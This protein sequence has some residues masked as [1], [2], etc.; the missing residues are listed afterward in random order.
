M[1]FYMVE[2]VGKEETA[3]ASVSPMDY[4]GY[5]TNSRLSL[6]YTT[7]HSI[8]FSMEVFSFAS[9]CSSFSAALFI[10]SCSDTDN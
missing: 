1:K 8:I 4:T 9:D 7:R 3:A 10:H 2:I 5:E 6:C